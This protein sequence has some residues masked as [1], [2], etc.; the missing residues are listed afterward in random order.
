MSNEM[1]LNDDIA[2]FEAPGGRAVTGEKEALPP[3]AW[4]GQC[5]YL[6]CERISGSVTEP[7]LA[8]SYGLACVEVGVV[9]G[10]ASALKVE[11][12]T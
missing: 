5:P 4:Q 11:K 7:A 1:S 10:C 8:D 12:F 2:H 3:P 6:R 9:D